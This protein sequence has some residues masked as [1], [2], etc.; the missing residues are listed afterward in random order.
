[1]S[2]QKSKV[3]SA[4]KAWFEE[5]YGKPVLATEEQ[6]LDA[7]GLAQKAR[8]ELAEVLAVIDKYIAYEAARTHALR[9]WMAGRNTMEKE[10][11]K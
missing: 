11:K 1:M 7:V 6:C 2:K 4:F 10:V 5:Q 9:G 8:Q 3:K